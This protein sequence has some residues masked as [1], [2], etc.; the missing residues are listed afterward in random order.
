MKLLRVP[1]ICMLLGG[2]PMQIILA[3][4]IFILTL[5][6]VIRQ[7]RNLSIGWSAL[8]M[9]FLPK[10]AAVPPDVQEALIYANVI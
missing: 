4:T 10:D 1:T 8:H 3:S 9:A 2:E 5:V 7:P 6:W